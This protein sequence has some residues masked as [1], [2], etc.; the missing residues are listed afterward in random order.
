MNK[1]IKLFL[2]STFDEKMQE[3]RDYFRNEI[4]AELNHIVGQIGKNLFLYDFELGIHGFDSELKEN[5]DEEYFKYFSN[6][7]DFC[8]EKIDESNYFV[9]IVG[10]TYGTDVIDELIEEKNYTGKFKELVNKGIDEELSVLELEFIESLE[11]LKNKNQKKVFFIKDAISESKTKVQKLITRI[12]TCTAANVNIFYYSKYE[13]ILSEIKQYFEKEF[14]NEIEKFTTEEKNRNLVYANKT[15][16]YIPNISNQTISTKPILEELD[17]YINNDSQKVFVLFGKTGSGKRTTLS[18]WILQIKKNSEAKIISAFAG[19]DG[20]TISEILLKIY[21]QIPANDK[22]SINQQ[23]KDEKS[24]L[25]KFAQFTLEISV[26]EQCPKTVIVIDGINQLEFTSDWKND[27]Y[28]W[29]NKQLENN[30]KVIVSAIDNIE[31]AHFA[32]HPMPSHNLSKLIEGYLKK[33]GKEQ[34]YKDFEEKL[35]FAKEERLPIF[36][37]LLCTEICMTAKYD[38]INGIL[39]KYKEISDIL[40]LYKEFLTRLAERQS[41]NKNTVQELCSYLYY[42]ENGLHRD[43]LQQLFQDGDKQVNSFYSLLYH[44]LMKNVD[45]KIVF[46]TLYFKQAVE[47]LFIDDNKEAEYRTAIINVLNMSKYSKDGAIIAERAYQIYRINDKQRMNNLLADIDN[48]EKL[49]WMNHIR[50]VEY[51]NLIEDKE[52]LYQCISKEKLPDKIIIFLSFYYN[53]IPN[54]DKSLE[55]SRK[56]LVIYE[57]ALGKEHPDTATIYNDIAEVYDNKSDYD[58]ALKYY[59]KALKIRKQVLGNKHLD[60]ASTYNSM[61]GIYDIMG[62]YDC[63]LRYYAKALKIFE[64]ILGKEH[65]HVATT[66]NNMAVV[67]DNKG[68]YSLTLKYYSKSLNIKEK[69][70]GKEHPDTATTYNGIGLV[71]YNIGDNDR[72]L[73]Y[74]AKALTIS[75]R[76]YGKEH[77]DT[78]ATYNGIGLVY[79]NKGDYDR[80]LEYYSKALYNMEKALD[81]KH[82]NIANTYNNVAEIYRL[83]SEYG[84]AL[85]YY[86][87]ALKNFE[88]VYGKKHPSIATIYNNMALVYDNMGD[89]NTALEYYEKALTIQVKFLDKGHPDI[90]ITYNNMGGIFY[91]KGE[92]DHSLEYLINALTIR[93]KVLGLVHPDTATTYNYMGGVYNSKGE[94]DRALEYYVKALDIYEKTLGNEHPYTA[95][96]Y[97]NIALVY[98]NKADYCRALKNYDKALDICEKVLGKRHPDTATTYNNIAR[99]YGAKGNY[100]LSLEYYN[101]A[102]D[103][104]ENVLGKA[105]PDTAA[106]FNDIAVVFRA[107]G[108]YVYAMEFYGKALGI[109]EAVLGKE[110]PDTATTYNNIGLVHR[111][112]GNYD[113]ALEYYNK[114]LEIRKKALSK[115]HPDTA[116]TYNNIAAA[117]HVLSDFDSALLFY[118]KSLNIYEKVMGKEY[119]DTKTVLNNMAIAFKESENPEPFDEWLK[120]NL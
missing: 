116:A 98:D 103:I 34:I 55:W 82:P 80:A 25:G 9:G 51:L 62:D 54:Y 41:L 101:K 92:Y 56:V 117:Y 58:L 109:R 63:A 118:T 120:K 47:E 102:L 53:E 11:N 89:Y 77:P 106:T 93:E 33:E 21:S 100:D 79:D 97:N 18:Q 107:Q 75:E 71:L 70:L 49:Y 114:A 16:Y 110:H 20:T 64:E 14:K 68:D 23:V 13:N 42:S 46:S 87:E 6:V 99:V 35:A 104:R 29:L 76:V 72:A 36:A 85:E 73:E 105:H 40:V 81:K 39:D 61:A 27:K 44:E 96:T 90:A 86:G 74:Y 115:E 52:N 38:T 60:T 19:V 28:W 10:N 43:T 95:S 22:S 4:N 59:R 91:N 66:F 113:L 2:S 112:Q 8:F 15:R 78:A 30:V 3:E 32:L 119:P 50:F 24:L 1:D 26:S 84:R 48:T 7:L 88:K 37:R 57:E 65:P 12:K 94:Y 111:V 45:D 67:Y 17:D 31:E 69:V 108:N 83:R 5:K